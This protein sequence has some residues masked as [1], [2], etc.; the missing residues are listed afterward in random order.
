MSL[1]LILI[2]F[3]YRIVFGVGIAAIMWV[4]GQ[5]V[6]AKTCQRY[7]MSR[8]NNHPD[9]A[10]GVTDIPLSPQAPLRSG[11]LVTVPDAMEGKNPSGNLA[12]RFS[13]RIQKAPLRN[14]DEKF[15][16]G[17]ESGPFFRDFQDIRLG[18][19]IQFSTPEGTFGYFVTTIEMIDPSEPL[20]PAL[21]SYGHSELTIIAS[22]RF[23]FTGAVPQQFVVHARPQ[24]RLK[25]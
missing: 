8:I 5:F 2:H 22:R 12:G 16:E 24:S 21:E 4:G 10:S 15:D 7:A 18:D 14:S 20:P 19:T 23:P 17:T 3:I 1:R 25:N 6:Y 9:I 13:G 11:I